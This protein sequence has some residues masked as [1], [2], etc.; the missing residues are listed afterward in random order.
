M[1]DKRGGDQRGVKQTNWQAYIHLVKGNIGPG[2]LTLPYAFSL[3][4]P[5]ASFIMTTVMA[6]VTIHNMRLLAHAKTKLERYGI[7]TYGE[8]GLYALGKAGQGAIEVFLV[9]MQLSIC[10]VYFSFVSA[11]LVEILPA[12]WGIGQRGIIVLMIVPVA[13]L[14]LV[15]H[16]KDLAIVSLAASL[17]FMS[18]LALILLLVVNHI[19]DRPPTE[20]LFSPSKVPIFLGNAVFAFEGIG[21][22]LPVE[23]AMLH[24]HDFL[25][26]LMWAMGTVS[27][28]F[29]IFG[30]ACLFSYGFISDGSI[31]SFL[32]RRGNSVEGN[33]GSY[34]TTLMQ[35]I[36]ISSAVILTY[37]LQFY[38]AIQL[39]E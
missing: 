22:V 20:V 1:G 36:L 10:I 11:N 27:F 12:S 37:P 34:A 33:G 16:M 14:A 3:V 17:F 26:V 31:T 24:P 28:I 23:N 25:P 15:R 32:Q 8:I 6:V 35:N 39:L 38:P 29:L 19:P 30:E 5:L 13:G 7:H 18:G 4:G 9:T 21:L 2:C